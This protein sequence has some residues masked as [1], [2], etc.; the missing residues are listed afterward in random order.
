[1]IFFLS[2]FAYIH[3]QIRREECSVFY[4]MVALLLVPGL[5]SLLLTHAQLMLSS[6]LVFFPFS[7]LFSHLATASAIPICV[8][9]VLVCATNRHNSHIVCRVW[10]Y[11]L[12]CPRVCHEQTQQSH[13]MSG[14]DLSS[15]SKSSYFEACRL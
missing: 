13:C 4:S 10:T 3:L 2:I 8:L 1:M 15:S 5:V 14:M 12:V 9:C 6:T 11:L 7:P